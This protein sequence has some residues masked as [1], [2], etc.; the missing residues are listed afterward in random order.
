MTRTRERHAAIHQLLQAGGSLGAISRSLSLSRP[1]VRRFARAASAD[2]LLD[3][4]M[5]ALREVRDAG[6]L[7]LNSDWMRLTPHGRL[8]SNEVFNRLLIPS[9]A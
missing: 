7:E 4:A 9:A 2:E 1:A 3:G 6:L 8:I 5:P